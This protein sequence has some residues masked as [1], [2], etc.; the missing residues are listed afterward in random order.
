MKEIYKNYFFQVDAQNTEADLLE[1]MARLVKYRIKSKAPKR[2]AS[3]I[4][5][6]PPGENM[7]GNRIINCY[8]GSGRSS[9][10][11]MISEKYGLVH[12]NSA[13]L[14]KDQIARKTE[15]GKLSLSMINKGEL[16]NIQMGSLHC[17]NVF[18]I[19]I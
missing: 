4:I 17:I 19:E 2:S 18:S 10:A 3:I 5:L 6:G 16:G 1:E 12:V 11:K 15:I 7:L 8:L 13:Q 9:Q 14:L